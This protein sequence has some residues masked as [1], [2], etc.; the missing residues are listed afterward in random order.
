MS[1]FDALISLHTSVSDAKMAASSTSRR[2]SAE[3]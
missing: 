1:A 3:L 2:L